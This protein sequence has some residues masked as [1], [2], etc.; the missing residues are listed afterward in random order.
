MSDAR[1]RVMPQVSARTLGDE[2]VLLNLDSGVYFGLDRVGMRIFNLIGDGRSVSEICDQLSAEFEA[3]RA[4]IE[5]DAAALVRDMVAHRL[6]E[7]CAQP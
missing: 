4:T 2:L 6:I 5:N 1:F 7:P 3:D